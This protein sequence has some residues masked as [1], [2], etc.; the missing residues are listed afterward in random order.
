MNK[1]ETNFRKKVRA[2]IKDFDIEKHLTKK[3][4]IPTALGTIAGGYLL[5]GPSEEK[6][7]GDTILGGLIGGVAGSFAEID[8]SSVYNEFSNVDTSPEVFQPKRIKTEDIDPEIFKSQD[9]LKNTLKK[10]SEALEQEDEINKDRASWEAVSDGTAHKEDMGRGKR[11]KASINND[12]Y[13]NIRE[14]FGLDLSKYETGQEKYNALQSLIEEIGS[15][16]LQIDKLN[17]VMN[18]EGKITDTQP[19]G[20]SGD[21]SKIKEGAHAR[22]G[23]EELLEWKRGVAASHNNRSTGPLR[24]SSREALYNELSQIDSKKAEDLSDSAKEIRQKIVQELDFRRTNIETTS[25]DNI[26]RPS[27][28]NK[29]KILSPAIR[30]GVIMSSGSRNPIDPSSI[31]GITPAMRIEGGAGL[32]TGAAPGMSQ[33]VKGR[34]GAPV[35]MGKTSI[36]EGGSFNSSAVPDVSGSHFLYKSSF[37]NEMKWDISPDKSLRTNNKKIKR[38]KSKGVLPQTS[39]ARSMAIAGMPV[40]SQLSGTGSIFHNKKSLGQDAIDGTSPASEERRIREAVNNTGEMQPQKDGSDKALVGE[41]ISEQEGAITE[42]S[43]DQ[44]ALLTKEQQ[45]GFSS[46]IRQESKSQGLF[47]NQQLSSVFDPEAGTLASSMSYQTPK[48]GGSIISAGVS[49]SP[50]SGQ[51]LKGALGLSTGSTLGSQLGNSLGMGSKGPTLQVNSLSSK[52]SLRGI[53]S[54]SPLDSGRSAESRARSSGA[55]LSPGGGHVRALLNPGEGHARAPF[56][57]AGGHVRAPFNPGVGHV[58]APFNPGGGNARAPLSGLTSPSSVARSQVSLLGDGFQYKESYT[59]GG[60]GAEGARASAL[61][62]QPSDTYLLKPQEASP[63]QGISPEEYLKGEL[64]SRREATAQS[65]YSQLQSSFDEFNQDAE[66]G[67]LFETRTQKAVKLAGMNYSVSGEESLI[68]RSTA[69]TSKQAR[70]GAP[71]SMISSRGH[72]ELTQL[73]ETR[74]TSNPA[75]MADMSGSLDGSGYVDKN[76][77]LLPAEEMPFAGFQDHMPQEEINELGP[78]GALERHLRVNMGNN[79]EDSRRKAE[80]LTKA[81]KGFEWAIRGSSLEVAT[82]ETSSINLP[83]TQNTREGDTF[84][85]RNGMTSPSRRFNAYAGAYE[86]EGSLTVK[87]SKGTRIKKEITLDGADGTLNASKGFHAEELLIQLNEMSGETTIKDLYTTKEH[88]AQSIVYMPNDSASVHHMSSPRFEISSGGKR[89]AGTVTYG[90]TFVQNKATD[91]PVMG[92]MSTRIRNGEHRSQMNRFAGELGAHY[93]YNPM[94]SQGSGSVTNLTSPES[95][96]GQTTPATHLMSENRGTSS[97]NAR[98]NTSLTGAQNEYIDSIAER[99]GVRA[100]RRGTSTGE[101]VHISQELSNAASN[102]FGDTISF[103][104]GTAIGNPALL[105]KFTGVENTR[106]RVPLIGKGKD[107][108]VRLSEFGSS[109]EGSTKIDGDDI[110]ELATMEPEERMEKIKQL[111][112][113]LSEEEM[114]GSDHDHRAVRLARQYSRGTLLDVKLGKENVEMIFEGAFVPKN[115]TKIF[116]GSAK[117]SV[118]FPEKTSTFNNLA[119]FSMM[120]SADVIRIAQ[121]ETF[122]ISPKHSTTGERISGLS[123]EQTVEELKL[124]QKSGAVYEA[125]MEKAKSVS[126][127]QRASETGQD[128]MYDLVSPD[129]GVRKEAIANLK[130]GLK[131]SSMM[132]YVEK[133]EQLEK[134]GTE[135]RVNKIIKD[136]Q[137]EASTKEAQFR[138]TPNEIGKERKGIGV[139]YKS[140]ILGIAGSLLAISSDK[141]SQD[142]LLTAGTFA[143]KQA[144]RTGDDKMLKI[145]QDFDGPT[146]V[147]SPGP[148]MDALIKIMTSKFG[149][150]GTTTNTPFTPSMGPSL[151]GEGSKGR[152]SWMEQK[153]LLSQG[154]SLEMI[155]NIAQLD[156]RNVYDLALTRSAFDNG[157]IKLS[158][159]DIKE[160]KKGLISKIFNTHPEERAEIFKELEIKNLD[161]ENL[162]MIN[163][164]LD[165]EIEGLKSV[166]VALKNTD[167]T[168]HYRLKGESVIT[169]A[170]AKRRDLIRA[171]LDLRIEK[172][173]FM[174]DNDK[175]TIKEM[176]NS[177]GVQRKRAALE[178]AA[179]EMIQFTK[180]S[181]RGDNDLVKEASRRVTESGKILI[182]RSVGGKANIAALKFADEYKAEKGK[183]ISKAESS[184][185]LAFMSKTSARSIFGSLKERKDGTPMQ[186]VMKEYS[187]GVVQPMIGEKIDPKNFENEKD[188]KTALEER[189]LSPMVSQIS[190]DP[191]LGPGASIGRTVMILEAMRGDNATVGIPEVD[192][193]AGKYQYMDYDYD[194]LRVA[195]IR[196]ET[197]Q[198]RLDYNK[199]NN[200]II[201]QLEDPLTMEIHSSLG[202]KGKNKKI[203]TS[204]DFDGISELKANQLDQAGMVRIRKTETPQG[205]KIATEMG[206]GLDLLAESLTS[207]DYDPMILERVIIHELAENLLKSGH[208]DEGGKMSGSV[209]ALEQARLSFRKTNDRKSFEAEVIKTI[210]ETVGGQISGLNNE[211][212]E[213]FSG[214][215]KNI[216]AAYAKAIPRLEEEGGTMLSRIVKEDPVESMTRTIDA[217]IE[218]SSIQTMPVEADAE[219]VRRGAKRTMASYVE[220]FEN[221]GRSFKKPLMWGG[222]ALA[223]G[224][225]AFK[226]SPDESREPDHQRTPPT[227]Q[228]QGLPPLQ[229]SSSYTMDSRSHTRTGGASVSMRAQHDFD[230]SP[231]QDLFGDNKN[232]NINVS[233]TGKY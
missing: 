39:Y 103:G 190:R 184:P 74:K 55:L 57:P 115:L 134:E 146:E 183:G 170:E 58:R 138:R 209:Q 158:D 83:F 179:Q 135:D 33:R 180:D 72:N 14:S 80:G 77:R 99:P 40:S 102:I 225:M 19:W 222:G 198:T 4:M 21:T 154:H 67:S 86:S 182:S 192:V 129:Q 35:G 160:V 62:G 157:D 8:F 178:V 194:I 196:L 113:V 131:D 6:H 208:K 15:D 18:H 117:S 53:Q 188:Y 91:D 27:R 118:Y 112:V 232:V 26:S 88:I 202:V 56:S 231:E 17:S 10:F 89:V 214:A 12:T 227:R 211:A 216:A 13:H 68:G 166:P 100:Y 116:G 212:R 141:T 11:S 122:S 54:I 75:V 114:V 31:L 61:D 60:W 233:D 156:P 145:V 1:R 143:A 213:K 126:I 203:K 155:D 132:A 16:T 41:H 161:L 200:S 139:E 150:D 85:E 174:R 230:S 70:E 51:V 221:V 42:R 226:S 147:A 22:P 66:T 34:P 133:I 97:V 137:T 124:G 43:K 7:P 148:K 228:R 136:I 37:E 125:Y 185:L 149:N 25:K 107:Q 46:T 45:Q 78:Q 47:N 90:K 210:N 151:S 49:F 64:R 106:L 163:I 127:V 186:L 168:G 207:G 71:F 101:R 175:A 109:L 218:A 28:D 50:L 142:L 32:Q 120:E 5:S 153:V 229:D 104:D 165:E 195:A 201:E 65:P 84:V 96:G 44:A 30:N 98:S 105:D 82:G 59:P 181:T 95:A 36:S 171:G 167:N 73:A 191:N 52:E 23:V 79:A 9:R 199:V 24:Y 169:R 20:A 197:D 92:E 205:T 189:K 215:I 111:N 123:F 81:L 140:K 29:S 121:D 162:S 217:R 130:E 38:D 224:A 119:A 187:Q 206:F 204:A 223:L 48:G 128:K 220:S 144:I 193:L 108:I 110:M 63:H 219:S 69:L 87:N 94:E 3:R 172:S 177:P 176:D 164:Q 76:L 93:G 173:A 2:K 159:L 152:S